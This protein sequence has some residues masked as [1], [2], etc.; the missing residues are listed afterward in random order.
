[1]FKALWVCLCFSYAV[2]FTFAQDHLQWGMR[3]CVD[4]AIKNSYISISNEVVLQGI[5]NERALLRDELLPNSSLKVDSRYNSKASKTLGQIGVNVQFPLFKPSSHLYIRKEIILSNQQEYH[6]KRQT[7]YQVSDKTIELYI[8]YCVWN[9][10]LGTTQK[11][12]K[13]F[14]KEIRKL[15]LSINE[16]KAHEYQRKEY[17]DLLIQEQVLLEKNM[18]ELE[19]R[20]IELLHYIGVPL[21]SNVLLTSFSMDSIARLINSEFMYDSSLPNSANVI[22]A[23][24]SH[25]RA[26]INTNKQK[27]LLYPKVSLFANS[28]GTWE[29]GSSAYSQI[30]SSLYPMLGVE[31]EFDISYI[32]KFK[33]NVQKVKIKE[34]NAEIQYR[35]QLMIEAKEDWL[36]C[37]EI[38]SGKKQFV[39]SEKRLRNSIEVENYKQILF[40]NG[41]ISLY[42]LE[43]SILKNREAQIAYIRSGYSCLRKILKWHLR[44]DDNSI[45]DVVSSLYRKE[46]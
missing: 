41:R 10:I 17:E 33:N 6:Q 1:M 45:W 40:Q 27:A 16:G 4:S 28:I 20:R 9:E 38:H 5:S 37:T 29:F 43:S 14:D 7:E 35:N 21:I 13:A 3:A 30:K 19:K 39:L 34:F 2:V 46:Q 18:E 8:D 23:D 25:K 12:V 32:W 42:E 44:K 24:L 15:A 26:V 22:L 36:M 31:L 11:R